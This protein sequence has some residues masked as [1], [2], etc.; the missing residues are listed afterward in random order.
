M[1]ITNKN[2]LINGA[3]KTYHQFRPQIGLD[4][5]QA[6]KGM[7]KSLR[8]GQTEAVK[9]NRPVDVLSVREQQTL[10]ALFNSSSEQTSF[11]GQTRTPRVQSGFL[12][13]IKG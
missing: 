4:P 8:A 9:I 11:Y 7:H 6:G 1:Q 13:D 3:E 12:L 5:A 10:Q 2:W